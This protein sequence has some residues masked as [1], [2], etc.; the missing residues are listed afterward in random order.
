MCRSP[1]AH[2]LFL[3]CGEHEAGFNRMSSE[4]R[5]PF[6]SQWTVG[7]SV[8]CWEVS[9]QDDKNF[10]ESLVNNRSRDWRKQVWRFEIRL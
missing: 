8:T 7:M 6:S 3:M 2:W 4:S 1:V 5:Y 10:L 9:A